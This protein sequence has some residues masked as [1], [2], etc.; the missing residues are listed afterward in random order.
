MD[1]QKTFA[2][3]WQRQ[4]LSESEIDMEKLIA[5]AVKFQRRVSFRNLTE[6][7]AAGLLLVLAGATVAS[8]HAPLF[9]RIGMTLIALGGLVVVAVLRLRG[10]AAKDKPGLG[11][12]TG[13]MMRWHRSELARQRDL[14][15]SVPV[16]YL[17]PFVPGLVVIFGG[18]WLASPASH[19]PR[20][21]LRA[22]I[23]AIVFLVVA[24]ANRRAARKLDEQMGELDQQLDV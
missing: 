14:L 10:H 8:G 20:I 23:V 22:A 17:A 21:A 18:S 15:R 12:A 2:E 13:E 4:P 16:W 7:V 19:V 9:V 5:K 6:Y 3:I 24:L 1:E 11:V